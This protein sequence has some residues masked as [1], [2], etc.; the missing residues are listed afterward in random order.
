VSCLLLIVQAAYL[1]VSCLLPIVVELTIPVCASCLV[2][3][4]LSTTDCG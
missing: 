1:W 3:G 4:E 2:V